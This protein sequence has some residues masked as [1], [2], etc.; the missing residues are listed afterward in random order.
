MKLF[1]ILATLVCSLLLLSSCAFVE[2]LRNQKTTPKGD[3]TGFAPAEPRFPAGYI[4]PSPATGASKML[5]P[6]T[7]A[8]QA[9]VPPR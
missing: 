1:C 8:I 2:G 7:Q 9:G 3:A 4:Q 5:V 6:V